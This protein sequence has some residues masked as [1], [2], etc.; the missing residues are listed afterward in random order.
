MKNKR[1]TL[2]G[3][4]LMEI[5]ISLAIL[6]VLTLVLV[7]T[8]TVINTYSKSTRNINQTVAAQAP[9]AQMG[10]KPGASTVPTSALPEVFVNWQG[11]TGATIAMDAVAY[12]AGEIATVAVTDTEGNIISIEE[13]N[14]LGGNLAMQFL[15]VHDPTTTATT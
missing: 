9:V 14:V 8:S 10:Y 13:A 1:K 12:Q 2:K 3:M 4:T 15:E 11:N 6:A 5:I 7:R